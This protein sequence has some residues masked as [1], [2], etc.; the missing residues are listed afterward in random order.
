MRGG[1]GLHLLQ[2]IQTYCNSA[3]ATNATGKKRIMGPKS[4]T[5]RRAP[6]VAQYL[7]HLGNY[8]VHKLVDITGLLLSH[9]A[10]AWRPRICQDNRVLAHPLRG[11]GGVP[12]LSVPTQSQGGGGA[13][14]AAGIG[15]ALQSRHLAPRAKI[16]TLCKRRTFEIARLVLLTVGPAPTP[17]PSSGAGMSSS[18]AGM[19]MGVSLAK[20]CSNSRPL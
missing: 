13:E 20:W 15:R 2:L 4:G 1:G 12:G 6:G 19:S 14:G 3:T 10:A 8:I 16:D 11:E 5:C 17:P 9:S 7:D 18:G